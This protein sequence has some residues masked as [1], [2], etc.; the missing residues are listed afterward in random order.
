MSFALFMTISWNEL[1]TECCRLPL[2]QFVK[3]VHRGPV[4]QYCQPVQ[5]RLWHPAPRRKNRRLSMISI[6]AWNGLYGSVLPVLIPKPVKSAKPP[7][8][9]LVS[10]WDS[11]LTPFKTPSIL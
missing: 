5:T 9:S 3:I 2:H 11:V 4:R 10:Q 6:D 7:G 8:T 1:T